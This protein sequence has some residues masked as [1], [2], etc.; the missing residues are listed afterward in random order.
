MEINADF[1]HNGSR[2]LELRFW[3]K[4]KQLTSNI[5]VNKVLDIVD[6]AYSN[7]DRDAILVLMEAAYF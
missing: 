1:G 4:R 5:N 7:I 3:K 2:L 6:V